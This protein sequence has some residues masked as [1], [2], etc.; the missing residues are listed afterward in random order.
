MNLLEKKNKK[1]TKTKNLFSFFSLSLFYGEGG[2]YGLVMDHGR[3]TPLRSLWWKW[4]DEVRTTR[5][6]TRNESRREE[7]N[8]NNIIPS[9]LLFQKKREIESVGHTRTQWR[10]W[11]NR[12][13]KSCVIMLL[14]FHSLSGQKLSNKIHTLL[15]GVGLNNRL[16]FVSN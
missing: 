5:C 10:G 4:P 15:N 14:L 7:N 8:N 13:S 16:F 2:I 1:K 3:T 6:G 12:K 11:D 9:L